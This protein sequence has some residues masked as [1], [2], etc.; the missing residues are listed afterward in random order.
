MIP[1]RKV[2][3]LSHHNLITSWADVKAAGIVGI[4]H[5]AMHNTQSDC[6]AC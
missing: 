1:N 2:L 6:V 5:K 4:I 3:D